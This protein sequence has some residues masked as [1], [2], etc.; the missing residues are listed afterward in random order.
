VWAIQVIVVVPGGKGSSELRRTQFVPFAS[1]VYIGLP[2]LRVAKI[3]TLFPEAVAVPTVTGAKQLDSSEFTSWLVGQEILGGLLP[4]SSTVTVKLQ[5]PPPV[6]D[7]TETVV[8]PTPKNDPDAGVA[9]TAPQ[10]PEGS[11][12]ANVT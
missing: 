7:V 5:L 3:V 2:S 4:V 11:A 6:S 9:V 1:Q 10:V 12:E 8:V